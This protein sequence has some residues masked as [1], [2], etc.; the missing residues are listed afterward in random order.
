MLK[1]TVVFMFLVLV[2]SV[3]FAAAP[4]ELV[5]NM[6]FDSGTIKGNDVMDLSKYGNKGVFKGAPKVAAGYKGDALSFAGAVATPDSVEMVTSVSLAKTINQISLEA[7][8]NPNK[9]A[10]M[11]VITKWDSLLN[12]MFHFE[13]QAGGIL[14]FCLRSGNNAADAV[15]LD[16]KTGGGV[17][18]VG[19][20]THL[21]E[22]YDGKT[23]RIYVNGAEVLN[24]AGV[25]VI[26]DS[27]NAKY[28]IGSLYT[29]DRF[30]SGSIDEARIWSKSLTA[31][32]VKKSFDGTLVIGLAVEREDKLATVWG[33]IKK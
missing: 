17:V 30:F 29:T 8:V 22:T 12:G 14:R 33:Q 18:P 25:G 10:L 11:E 1:I 27:P 13:I 7:W 4:D 5:L 31:D 2:C 26:R 6:S 32:E 21:A 15:I 19:K 28:W 24:G 23:A 9:D 20:W 16:I 3:S